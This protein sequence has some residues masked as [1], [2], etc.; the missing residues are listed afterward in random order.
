MRAPKTIAASALLLLLSVAVALC[1]GEFVVRIKNSSMRNYDI[2]MWRY[3]R[4]LKVRSDN[5]VLGHEHAAA[6]SAVLQSVNIRINEWGLR[7]GPVAAPA[8]GMRRILFLGGSVT[9]G[10]GVAEQDTL[11]ERLQRKFAADGEAVEVLNAGIA[12]YNATR[13]V[14][15]FVTRLAGLHPTDIVVHYFLRD[16]EVLA[17]AHSNVLL[18]H[19]ELAATL[20][21]AVTRFSDPAAHQSLEQYYAG[22][23]RPG[24]NGFNQTVAALEKLNQYARSNGIRLYLAVTPHVHDMVD[25]RFD[26]VHRMMEQ[27]AADRGI[28]FID[29]LPAMRD[30]TPQQLWSMPGDPHPNA[31]GHQRMADALYPALRLPVTAAGPTARP[32]P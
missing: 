28:R 31:L 2:E 21:I 12:N 6:K 29:L 15:R 5:P 24:A 8:V 13:Y 32:A 9:L 10:W 30:L 26:Y 11:T 7:G 22:L 18:Q 4:E 20:W 16:A 25:Y 1:L 19:S 17:P 27:V 23:Y 3:G 14:E